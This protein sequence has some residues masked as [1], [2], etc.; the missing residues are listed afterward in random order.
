MPQRSLKT[1]TLS[2]TPMVIRHWLRSRTM[3]SKPLR[4]SDIHLG[5]TPR[6]EPQMHFAN[7]VPRLTGIEILRKEHEHTYFSWVHQ[8]FVSRSCTSE[9]R[10]QRQLFLLFRSLKTLI[11]LRGINTFSSSVLRKELRSCQ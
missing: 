10:K 8:R 5:G 11:F 3:P 9:S 1:A 7:H 6:P 2:M 4:A